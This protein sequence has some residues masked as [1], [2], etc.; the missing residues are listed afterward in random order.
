MVW[1]RQAFSWRWRSCCAGTYPHIVYVLRPPFAANSGVILAVADQQTLLRD[2]LY[3]FAVNE[4][5]TAVC[6]A[7]QQQ[8]VIAEI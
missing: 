7:Q 3:V 1:C 4:P 5:K 6:R 8:H 2:L